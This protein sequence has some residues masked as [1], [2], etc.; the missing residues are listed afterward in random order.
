LFFY[1]IRDVHPA[2]K[3][4]DKPLRIQIQVP[5]HKSSR[6]TR[7]FIANTDAPCPIERL[8]HEF[9][10]LRRGNAEV[11]IRRRALY[12]RIDLNSAARGGDHF[13]T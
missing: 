3:I 8:A 1:R 11:L 4:F 2:L 6:D 10:K 12:T 9:P 5:S 7:F 13:D